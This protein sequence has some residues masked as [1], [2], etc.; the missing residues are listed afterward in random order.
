MTTIQLL[1]FVSLLVCSCVAAPKV[2][3]NSVMLASRFVNACNPFLRQASRS[4]LE[5][6]KGA[7]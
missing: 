3:P 1:E 6:V 2:D 4:F 5:I 7:T